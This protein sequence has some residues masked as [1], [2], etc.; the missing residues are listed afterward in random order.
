[1]GWILLVN[2]TPKPIKFESNFKSA[3]VNPG[4]QLEVDWAYAVLGVFGTTPDVTIR[5]SQWS[6]H[7]NEWNS[8]ER[9]VVEKSLLRANS[10]PSGESPPFEVFGPGD[11]MRDG[12]TRDG[13]R[14]T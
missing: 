2:N 5:W 12:K 8:Y 3:T 13:A 6:S 4:M 10:D 9:L 7:F 14:P 1:M 11:C